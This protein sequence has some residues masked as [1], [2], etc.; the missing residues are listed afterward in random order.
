MVYSTQI[1]FWA[2]STLKVS[3]TTF[4]PGYTTTYLNF[5][6]NLGRDQPYTLPPA[7]PSVEATGTPVFWEEPHYTLVEDDDDDD[8]WPDDIDFDNVLPRADDRD[9]NGIL[10]YQEDFLIFE[11]DPSCLYRSD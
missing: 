8:D 7:G 9:Q 6:S 5:G 2:N 10:D 3:Y 11:A 4:D 1:P